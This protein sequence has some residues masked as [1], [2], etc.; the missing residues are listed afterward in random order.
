MRMADKKT[1][2]QAKDGSIGY[3]CFLQLLVK[4]FG[5]PSLSLA[6]TSSDSHTGSCSGSGYT[7]NIN[8]KLANQYSGGTAS[9]FN[10]LPN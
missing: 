9:D 6:G 2:F 4:T 3:S 5:I 1:V 7:I 8:T 10:R